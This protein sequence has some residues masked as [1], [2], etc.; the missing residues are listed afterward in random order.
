MTNPSVASPL[1]SRNGVEIDKVF[2]R[3]VALSDGQF[4]SA[5]GHS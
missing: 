3:E 2:E 5:A 4:L 1:V